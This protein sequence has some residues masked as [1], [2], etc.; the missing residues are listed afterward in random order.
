[1]KSADFAH[2]DPER[3]V[4]LLPVG[5]IEQHGPHLPVMVD[6]CINQG[7]VGRMLE[8]KPADLPA[9]V[10]PMTWVGRSEEHVDFPGTLTHTA[11]TLRR[12]WYE[13]GASVRRAGVR[14][15]VILNSHGGQ[16]QVMQ[17]V[18]R[19]L[20]IDHDM[21]VTC[22]SWGQLGLPDGVIDPAER[23]HG[24]HAGELETALM[25]AL[26]PELVAMDE[27]ADFVPLSKREAN[28]FPILMGLGAAGY[29]WQA[30]DVDDSGA[31]GN[32]AAA[33]AGRGQ[34]VI[35]HVADRL[36][37]LLDEVSR[38]PLA[39]L[40]DGPVPQEVLTGRA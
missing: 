37:A 2:V 38:Y 16:I 26:R 23:Q 31:A 11:E 19:Q 15:L 12:M 8:R 10:L 14:K 3:W 34:Q 1:M 20:R 29:G 40:K 35:D 13:I 9:T 32:A 21:F 33:D 22:L 18:A 17:I 25:L 7:I 28:R 6:A 39:N 4:A 36:V 5:A 24:I 30:Q 27:A